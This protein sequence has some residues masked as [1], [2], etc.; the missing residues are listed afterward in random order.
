MYVLQDFECED[1][2]G[3]DVISIDAHVKELHIQYE[4]AQPDRVIVEDKM[5]RTFQWRRRE[6]QNSMSA[7]EAIHKYPFLK[8]LPG[9]CLKCFFSCAL[10]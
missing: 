10:M 5:K 2:V 7:V 8:T 6:L 4:R 1:A 3:E 9:V